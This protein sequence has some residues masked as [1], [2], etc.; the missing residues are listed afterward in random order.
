MEDF[1]VTSGREALSDM[2]ADDMAAGIDVKSE[3][4]APT[5]RG[6]EMV[7]DE[8]ARREEEWAKKGGKPLGTVAE[9][10]SCGTF[11][12]NLAHITVA[13]VQLPED[14]KDSQTSRRRKATSSAPVVDIPLWE[15][16]LFLRLSTL[17]AQHL[18][19]DVLIFGLLVPDA[20]LQADEG[21]DAVQAGQCLQRVG[22]LL[23]H[24]QQDVHGHLMG[25]VVREHL[26]LGTNHRSVK[27]SSGWQKTW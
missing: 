18:L 5:A 16:S 3:K 19:T 21:S 22:A 27:S 6:L 9:F 20:L 26:Q 10:A 15:T 14:E 17:H 24:L 13:F 23:L 4:Y 1:L 2:S 25:V 8:Q 7:L 11:V 12:Q